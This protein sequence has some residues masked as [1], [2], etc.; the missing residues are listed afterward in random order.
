MW[1]LA[2]G[3]R[4][5]VRL[6]GLGDPADAAP[7]PLE[8]KAIALAATTSNTA[9]APAKVVRFATEKFTKLPQAVEPK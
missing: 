6:P 5:R 3:G 9:A 1:S 2:G 4:S 7:L 8:A